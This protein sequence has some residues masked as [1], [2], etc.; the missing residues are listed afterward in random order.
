MTE[1]ELEYKKINLQIEQNTLKRID[2]FAK[3]DNRTRTSYLIH[4]A[5]LRCKAMESMKND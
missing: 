4:A 2:K 1:R 3:K 5:L